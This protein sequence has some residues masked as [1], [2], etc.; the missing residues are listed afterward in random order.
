M[1][2]KIVSGFLM[3]ALI[4]STMG[5]FV[6]CKDYDEDIYVDLK[7]RISDQASLYDALKKQVDNLEAAVAALEQAKC[8]CQQDALKDYVKFSDLDGYMTTEDGSK[9][10]TIEEFVQYKAN[11]NAAIQLLQDAIDALQTEL[12]NLKIEVAKN[13][14]SIT[15]LTELVNSANNTAIEAKAKAEEALAL[16]KANA[17]AIKELQEKVAANELN[18]ASLTNVVNTLQKSV[19]NVQ[20]TIQELNTTV[21]NLSNTVAGWDQKLTDLLNRTEGIVAQVESNTA[22]IEELEK[23]YQELLAANQAL[24]DYEKVQEL[25][26]QLRYEL[27]QMNKKWGEDLEKA[28]QEALAAAAEAKRIAEEAL[29]KAGIA[30]STSEKALTTASNAEQL[31][32]SALKT[33]QMAQSAADQAKADAEAAALAAQAALA[34]VQDLVAQAQAAQAAAEAAQAAAEA[35]AALAKQYAEEAAAAGGGLTQEWKDKIEKALADAAAAQATADA[36]KTAAQAAQAAADAAQAKAD[37]AQAAADAAQAKAN[38]LENDVNE[39]KEAVKN[40]VTESK[41][42]EELAKYATNADLQAKYDELKALIDAIEIGGIEGWDKEKLDQLYADVEALKQVNPSGVTI[43]DVKNALKDYYTKDEVNE[44]LKDYMTSEQIQ[45]NYFTKDEINDKIKELNDKITPLEE[46][47]SQIQNELN[48]MKSALESLKIVSLNIQ[49]TDNPTIGYF[50]LPLNVKSHMLVVYYGNQPRFVFPS[51]GTFDDNELAAMGVSSASEIP[52]RIVHGGGMFISGDK[53]NGYEGNAGTVYMTINPTKA[54]LDDVEFSLVNSQNVESGV[55]LSKPVASTKVLKFGYGYT[56]AGNELGFYESKATLTPDHIS[57]NLL[58]VDPEALLAQAQSTLDEKSLDGVLSTGLSFFEAFNNKVDCEAVKA[59]WADGVVTSDFNIAACAVEPLAIDMLSTVD[60]PGIP[61][62]E[63]LKDLVAE[64]INQIK[65]RVPDIDFDY[66]T[67]TDRIQ[68]VNVE[69]LD[70]EKIAATLQVMINGK[71]ETVRIVVNLPAGSSSNITLTQLIDAIMADGGSVVITTEN[72][73][74]VDADLN[75][76]LT[77][78]FND[79]YKINHFDDEMRVSIE[80]AKQNMIA[81]LQP[82]I[83]KLYDRLT[84]YYG[85]IKN[86]LDLIVVARQENGSVA[87]L[88]KSLAMP[89]KAAGKLD[90]IP[91]SYTLELFAPAYKK[92]IAVTNVYNADGTP[93]DKAL[94]VQA[95]SAENMATV[96]DGKVYATFEGQ[97]GYIYEI[98]LAAVDYHAK[99]IKEKFYVQF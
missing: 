42:A 38:Q 11:N 95:N 27:E 9:L 58:S 30:I 76:V 23:L 72:G 1:K 36:A 82:Y 86:M 64:I 16:A 6:S 91:T 83:V 14:S 92:I 67:Y 24:A 31:A 55:K 10:L 21:Q 97:T 88:S 29:T 32:L 81:G 50:N 8:N 80:E 84:G 71:M 41:L 60:L 22:R 45:N 26:N 34:Q 65:I 75:L 51:S 77:Q 20:N 18:I 44:M 40:F 66:T 19:T 25:I 96:V 35:A 46:T 94:A 5:S 47:V 69:V 59:K 89:T 3:M 28:K 37:A 85:K 13:T 2:R 49:G 68:F 74:H 99:E 61:G 57:G 62:E 53:D 17:A 98:T 90:L 54:N 15:R 79:L 33:A 93:A 43:E 48:D 63:R 73:S 78:L 70:G 56:R 4:V 7:D 12:A 52:G 39:L 87:L